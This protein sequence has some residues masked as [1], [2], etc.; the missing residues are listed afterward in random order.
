[1]ITLRTKFAL[2]AAVVALGL[3]LM[4]TE[5]CAQAKQQQRTP[6]VFPEGALSPHDLNKPRLK[7]PFNL[8]GTWMVDLSSGFSSFMFGPNYPKFKP[9]AQATFDAGKKATAQ[10]LT[11][12]DDIGKCFPAGM[13]MIMTRVWPIA[14]FQPS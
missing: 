14:M 13:P 6:D 1:M 12:H 4:A 5:A 9:E 11:F 2:G 7:A 8:T 3:S 10:G